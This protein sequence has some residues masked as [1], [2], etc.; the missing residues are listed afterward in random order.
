MKKN[1]DDIL[2]EAHIPDICEGEIKNEWQKVSTRLSDNGKTYRNFRFGKN[3]LSTGIILIGSSLILIA[4]LLNF[5][6]KKPAVQT[7]PLSPDTQTSNQKISKNAI[8][9]KENNSLKAPVHLLNDHST[10]GYN[11]R[12]NHS[13]PAAN[14]HGAA[15]RIATITTENKKLFYVKPKP[16]PALKPRLPELQTIGTGIEPIETLAFAVADEP[17]VN[18]ELNHKN[19]IHLNQM[20][21]PRNQWI[22]GISLRYIPA[23]LKGNL[24]FWNQVGAGLSIGKKIHNENYLVSGLEYSEYNIP[25]I[26]FTN[27]S[28]LTYG[29]GSSVQYASDRT[30]LNRVGGIRIPLQYKINSIRKMS[31]RFGAYLERSLFYYGSYNYTVKDA[32]GNV[33]STGNSEESSSELRQINVRIFPNS[34]PFSPYRNINVRKFDAGLTFSAGYTPDKNRTWEFSVEGNY[35]LVDFTKTA[36]STYYNKYFIAIDIRKYLPYSHSDV[37]AKGR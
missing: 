37:S 6:Q 17:E 27:E 33:V 22:F 19:K 36:N 24:S 1:I 21:K 7:V 15:S 10:G 29:S 2:R 20:I 4:L 16:N 26:A 5:S 18:H 34:Q 23:K 9:N 3:I 31:I 35:G 8:P 25:S 28:F 32:A 11:S 30:L 12:T 14:Q 13:V